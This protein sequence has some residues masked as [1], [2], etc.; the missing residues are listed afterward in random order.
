MEPHFSLLPSCHVL[1]LHFIYIHLWMFPLRNV[2]YFII[3]FKI[4]KKGKP[5]FG[6]LMALNEMMAHVA[7]DPVKGS[8]RM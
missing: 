8:N 4:I 7:Y 1:L 3:Y 5:S 2:L 6:G